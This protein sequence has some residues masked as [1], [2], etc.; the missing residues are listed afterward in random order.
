[1]VH[2]HNV[3]EAVFGVMQFQGNRPTCLA[4]PD[5]CRVEASD[6]PPENRAKENA[7]DAVV[8]IRAWFL[9]APSTEAR[10][11]VGGPIP[12]LSEKPTGTRFAVLH[13]LILSEY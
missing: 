13:C 7:E 12:A 5:G 6:A 3:K 8:K 1:M 2:P 4:D 11:G 10:C 9:G